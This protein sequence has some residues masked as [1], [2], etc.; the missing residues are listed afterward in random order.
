MCER[1]NR[2]IDLFSAHYAVSGSGV[3]GNPVQVLPDWQHDALF[4]RA[5]L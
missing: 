3:L 5:D 2:K 4:Y 1:Y